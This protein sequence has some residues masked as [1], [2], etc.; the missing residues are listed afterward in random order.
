[1]KSEA[2][3]IIKNFLYNIQSVSIGC[4]ELRFFNADNLNEEQIGYR[5][6]PDGNSL[7]SELEGDW[8]NNWIVIGIDESGDPLIV[9]CNDIDLPVFQALSGQD[10][11]SPSQI[12]DSL[13]KFKLIVTELKKLSI[14]RENP[15]ELENNPFT[16]VEMESFHANI[17]QNNQPDPWFWELFLDCSA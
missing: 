14:G 12:A 15:V 7:I 8:Q 6:D 16:L 17:Q 11:W 1:M 10:D 9:D 2:I 4:N 5:V 3:Q 13:G